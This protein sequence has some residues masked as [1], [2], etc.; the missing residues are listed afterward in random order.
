MTDQSPD[1]GVEPGRVGLYCFLNC[2]R[3]CG[4]D[5]M[6]YLPVVPEGFDYRTPDEE[7]R[8][9]AR[10]MVLVNMH[11]C[12]KHVVHIAAK[13]EEAVK[14]ARVAA[15]DQQR[16]SAVSSPSSIPGSVR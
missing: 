13:A 14:L 6:A 15:A 8:Q 16:S 1:E 7:A 2:E 12:G 10:C 11:K 4:P 5:C 9:W 3:E